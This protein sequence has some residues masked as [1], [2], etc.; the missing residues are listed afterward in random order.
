MS[1]IFGTTTNETDGI[2]NWNYRCS[3]INV[4][5]A[6]PLYVHGEAGFSGYGADTPILVD[7]IQQ[8]RLAHNIRNIT[9]VRFGNVHDSLVFGIGTRIIVYILAEDK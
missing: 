1:K 3:Y 5:G 7:Y 2:K 4:E 8:N 6:S 9:G